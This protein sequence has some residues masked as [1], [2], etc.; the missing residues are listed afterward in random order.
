MTTAYMLIEAKNSKCTYQAY[1]QCRQ[2]LY[3]E[4]KGFHCVDGSPFLI[5][6]VQDSKSIFVLEDL[7]LNE[8]IVLRW[9]RWCECDRTRIPTTSCC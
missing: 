1:F 5:K 8:F 6:N 4:R 2:I 7:A 9:K 3:N